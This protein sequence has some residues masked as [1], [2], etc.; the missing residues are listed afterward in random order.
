MAF[1][2]PSSPSLIM[3]SFWFKVRNVQL[4]LSLEHL[5]AT[6]GL[7]IGLISML[8]CLRE[9]GGPRKG[10][11]MGRGQSME[12]SEHTHLWTKFV[13]LYECSSCHPKQFHQRSLITDNHNIIIIIIMKKF[14]VLWELPNVTQ[15]PK[16]NKCCWKN[17]AKDLLNAGLPQIFSLYKTY[18]RSTIKQNAMKW[19]MPV[20]NYF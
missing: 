19:G 15:R 8:L 4:F 17:G 5:V 9:Q 7:L 20:D 3:S 13:V 12:P 11:E 10:R 14:E 18:L 6:V 2:M 16:V 1:N